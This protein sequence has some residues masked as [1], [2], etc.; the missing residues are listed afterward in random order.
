M[1]RQAAERPENLTYLQR[2]TGHRITGDNR[3]ALAESKSII[4]MIKTRKIKWSEHAA[5]LQIEK[6]LRNMATDC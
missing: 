1:M 4:R 3:P 6:W 2:I 5:R